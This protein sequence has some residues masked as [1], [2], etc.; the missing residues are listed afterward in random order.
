M[1][2]N[3]ITKRFLKKSLASEEEL[4]NELRYETEI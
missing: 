1:E 3:I 2:L 4:T